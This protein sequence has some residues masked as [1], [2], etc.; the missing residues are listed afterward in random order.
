MK[1]LKI[2]FAILIV[3]LIFSQ[4]GLIAQSE[5]D[6]ILVNNAKKRDQKAI[7]EALNGWWT[8]SMRNH[9]ERIEWWKEARFGMFVH[10]GVYSLPA[11][12]WKGVPFKGYAEHLMRIKKIPRSEYLELAHQFNPSEFNAMEWIS[13]AKKAGMKYFVITA[14]H[15]D[16]FAMYDSK[17][18]DYN[19]VKQ[20]QFKRDPM[21]ELAE[22][23]KKQ[24]IKFGFYYSHAFDW[25]DPDAPGNDWDYNN[26]GGDLNLFGG[27]NWFDV[28][29]ELLPKA[30][31][32]VNN[33]AIP[34]IRELILKYHPDI[35]W[36]DTPHKLP[37]SEN[38][39]ILKTIREIDTN[40]VINGRL[41]RNSEINFGDYQNTADRPAE[42]FPV[43]GNWEA[44][45]TTNESYGYHKFDNSHKPVSHFIRLIANAASRG[46]NLLMNIG[47]MGN[48]KID[49]KDMSILNG[50]GHWMNINGEAI[51]GTHSSP[52]PLQS[53]G[54][55]TM[56]GNKVYL[57]VFDWPEDRMLIIGG[58]M[59]QINKAYLL[60]DPGRNPLKVSNYGSTDKVVSVPASPADSINTVIVL[61]VAEPVEADKTRLLAVQGAVNRLL[62]YD[63]VTK[64][65]GFSYGDGKAKRYYVEGWKK[66][67]QKLNWPLRVDNFAT[68]KISLLYAGSPVSEG[69]F[70]LESDGRIISGGYIKSGQVT[71][72]VYSMDLGRAEFTPGFHELTLIPDNIKGL[73]LMK[74]LEIRLEPVLNN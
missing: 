65:S 56:K 1:Y 13:A 66:T 50:I 27:A 36:F 4:S 74:I 30:I 19:I 15:H 54:V 26:P 70:H 12:E 28:H 42:F 69:S 9:D 64:G 71:G 73:E 37:L 34:Q 17:V 51:H 72:I 46:G 48:G 18:S 63:A 60:S 25:E 59:S 32:Y 68:Y 24:D 33:K 7:D 67:D 62:A 11:G 40:V 22:A 61:E 44:I 58:L 55:T 21:A 45:P 41:A 14:K 47:P 53:W 6:A 5:K 8:T 2:C 29:P 52:L 16:G 23:C 20:T 57:H 39:R 31:N 3:L 43:T 38:L 10:W 35:M 49:P